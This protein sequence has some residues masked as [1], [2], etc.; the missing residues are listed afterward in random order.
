MP[1][2]DGNPLTGYR[3]MFKVHSIKDCIAYARDHALEEATNICEGLAA[4]ENKPTDRIIG[5]QEC[6]QKIKSLIEQ[7]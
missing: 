7:P 2:V 1:Y 6:A 5:Y 3:T 4:Q